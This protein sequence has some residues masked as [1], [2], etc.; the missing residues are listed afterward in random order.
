MSLVASGTSFLAYTWLLRGTSDT[1]A[2]D[3][4]FQ[5]ANIPSAVAGTISGTLLYLLPPWFSRISIR[6]QLAASIYLC[7]LV[8]TIAVT[9]LAVIL[10]GGASIQPFGV[11]AAA[12][13]ALSI[14]ISALNVGVAVGVS[15]AQSRGHYLSSGSTPLISA[16]ALLAGSLAAVFWKTPALIL[17]GQLLGAAIAC[18]AL[19][20]EFLVRG[21]RLGRLLRAARR[22][23][24]QPLMQQ[25][26][27]IFIGTMAFTMFPAI[28]TVLCKY[29]DDGS[30]SV[31]SYAQRVLVASGTAISLG[32]FVVAARTSR[33]SLLEG[34]TT[35]LL[36]RARQEVARI[37]TSGVVL[38]IVFMMFGSQVLAK[39][40]SGSNLSTSNIADLSSCVSIMLI[41]V[42]PMTAVPYIFRVYYSA[43]LTR[44][45]ALI[46][47]AL[48][49]IYAL[50]SWAMLN[51]F[52]VKAL[53]VSYAICWWV[54]LA[55]SMLQL[56]LQLKGKLAAETA[57]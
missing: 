52:G 51:A 45:P 54:G 8:V 16:I 5:A 20:R 49:A 10:I 33:D 43:G 46:G 7:K 15:I 47:M 42:G 9:A 40:F 53:A 3:R 38:F 50:A 37:V 22:T 57:R 17:V 41:A 4:V 39:L 35:A 24:I 26:I 55:V 6:H 28:D 18:L 44:P 11:M 1:S 14:V 13:I 56:P 23:S 31:M 36:T 12:L 2:L 48:P 21:F 34:G 32:A 29:L 30:L 27:P 25:A 19:T